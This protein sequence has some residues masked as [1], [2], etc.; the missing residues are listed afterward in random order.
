MKEM[1]IVLFLI[2]SSQI[3]QAQ[4]I[5]LL[6]IKTVYIIPNGDEKETKQ[7]KKKIPKELEWIIVQDKSKADALILY[8]LI[9]SKGMFHKVFAVLSNETPTETLWRHDKRGWIKIAGRAIRK[10]KKDL[11]LLRQH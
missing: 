7:F 8:E 6:D 4:D 10:L 11:A 1:L 5:R 2:F 9:G 3:T